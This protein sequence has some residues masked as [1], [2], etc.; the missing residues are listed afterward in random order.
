MKESY[1]KSK[2]FLGTGWGFPPTFHD[3]PLM[4]VEMVSNEHDI[5]EALEILLNTNLG[6]RVMLPE[7]G[8]ELQHFVFQPITNS[9]IHFLR[10][11]IRT[12]ILYY[13]PRIKVNDIQIDQKDYQE[14]IIRLGIKYTIKSNNSRF[15]LVFPYYK[16]EGTDIPV[17]YHKHV[18][19]TALKE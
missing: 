2:S 15:N 19:Q 9:R 4:G 5:K 13:E 11:I 18:R 7:Y 6:E 8:S 10:D 14:G 12:A 17:L 3:D 1:K 16:Q